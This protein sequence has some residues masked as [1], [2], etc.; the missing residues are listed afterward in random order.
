M[1][2]NG[3]PKGYKLV[4]TEAPTAPA[5]PTVGESAAGL[6]RDVGGADINV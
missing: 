4:G 6:L 5:G 3:I 2:D 1:A